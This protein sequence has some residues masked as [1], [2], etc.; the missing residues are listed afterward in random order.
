MFGHRSRAWLLPAVSSALLP[1]CSAQEGS[2]EPPLATSEVRV[3]I[4]AERFD[5]AAFG[6]LVD[7]GPRAVPGLLAVL[8][9]FGDQSE[10]G[11]RRR[12]RALRCLRLIGPAVADAVVP[13]LLD[14]VARDISRDDVALLIT[15]AQLVPG[16]TDK[17]RMIATVRAIEIRSPGGQ[18]LARFRRWVDK[19][20]LWYD[21][22]QRLS[23]TATDDVDALARDLRGEDPLRRRFAAEHLGRLGAAAA[24]AIDVL[25]ETERTEKHPRVT[26]RKGV[27]SLTADFHDLVRDAAA[28]AIARIDP[29]RVEARRGLTLLLLAD[30]PDERL[31]A[32]MAMTPSLAPDAFDVVPAVVE[33][34]DDADLRVAEE[35]V[36]TLGRLGDR[37]VVV[38]ERLRELRSS[39]DARLQK[40]AAAALR[41]L[42]R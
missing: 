25:I 14:H 39:S 6:A 10:L 8:G 32:L 12:M 22:H 40:R 2:V 38:I 21:V 1:L 30:C 9:D 31:R 37:R 4:E 5:R 35:A 29:A 24:P 11:A 17:E 3:V 36:S 19:M 23:W 26:R 18:P 27:G 20:R 15:V 28:I 7:A 16:V 42:D 13:T 41:S 33:A 34:T